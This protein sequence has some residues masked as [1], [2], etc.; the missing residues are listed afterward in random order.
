PAANVSRAVRP[1]RRPKKMKVTT[2]VVHNTILALKG[3][4]LIPADVQ[5]PAWHPEDCGEVDP[6]KILNMRN[7]LLALDGDGEGSPRLI[8][9]TPDFFSPSRTVEYDYDPAAAPPTQWL[10]FLGQLWPGDQASIESL[11]EWAGYIVSGET[12]QQKMLL[13]VGP[14]RA[15]KGTIG[16]VLSGLIGEENVASPTFSTLAEQFGLQPLL[17]KSLAL[18]NDARPPRRPAAR[19]APPA[20]RQRRYRKSPADQRR[21]HRP[22]QPQIRAPP[23][24]Q[25]GHPHRHHDERD[26]RLRGRQRRLGQPVH[27]P[28]THQEL[29]RQRG[30]HARDPLARRA[31]RHPQLG[32]GRVATSEGGRPLRPAAVGKRCRGPDD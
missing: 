9:H 17:H 21:G 31:A 28:A 12:A 13:I 15:G 26:A 5:Q 14:P 16:K 6:K 19:R 23:A 11:Q 18:I 22:D 8:P 7:G 24:D 4:T 27:R 2:T 1:P 25:V 32:A 3:L 20:G 10:H 29:V 30:S